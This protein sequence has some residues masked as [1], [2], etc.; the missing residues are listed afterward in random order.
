[1]TDDEMTSR[2][3]QLR[4]DLL[5]AAADA[6][7]A[8]ITTVLFRLGL[9]LGVADTAMKAVEAVLGFHERVGLYGNAATEGEPGNCPHHPDSDLHF[10]DGDGSGEWLCEGRPEGA[11]CS[12]CTDADGADGEHADWPCAEYEAILAALTGKAA[13][14]GH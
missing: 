10:E 4:A 14:G 5:T 6:D 13:D 2:L 9:A 7:G 1:M 3:A 12:S 11:V 8:T